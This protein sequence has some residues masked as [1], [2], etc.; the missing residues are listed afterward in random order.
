M[1]EDVFHVGV[2]AVITDAVGRALLLRADHTRLSPGASAFWDLPGGRVQ[3]GESELEALTRELAEEIGAS[4]VADVVPLAVGI[5]TTRIPAEAGTV[6]LVYSVFRCHVSSTRLPA[7]SPEHSEFGW[8]TPAAAVELL[9][10]RYPETVCAA[11]LALMSPLPNSPQ[12]C[13]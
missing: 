7:L 1:P 2:K 8:H 4:E 5:S 10:P 11:I 9:R 3:Q 12:P 13:G 6:G